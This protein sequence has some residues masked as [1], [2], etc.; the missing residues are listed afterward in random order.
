MIDKVLL[1]QKA[2]KDYLEFAN[3]IGE[4]FAKEGIDSRNIPDEQMQELANGRAEIF[5]V[6][7]DKNKTRVS[8]PIEAKDWKWK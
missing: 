4:I 8:F 3:E 7:P 5:I 6:L 1:T 2:V